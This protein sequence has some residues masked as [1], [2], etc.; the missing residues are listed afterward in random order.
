[1][2]RVAVLFADG[3]EEI[4][5]LTP[6]DYLRRAGADVSIVSLN[7]DKKATGSHN[8]TVLADANLDDLAGREWDA[9]L[10]PGGMPGSAN[11]A[12]SKQVGDFVKSMAAAGKIV[13]AICAAPAVVLTP[14]GLLNGRKFTCYPG[15]EQDVTRC[16]VAG[17]LAEGGSTGAEWSAE[18]VVVDGNII[19]SRGAGTAGAWSITLIGRLLGKDTAKKQADSIVFGPTEGLPL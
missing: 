3:F 2:K 7:R 18:G 19:T 5:A 1:M 11:L 14:L 12:A 10:L 8:I 9:V 4:E 17:G 6:V 13:A 16:L 15:K